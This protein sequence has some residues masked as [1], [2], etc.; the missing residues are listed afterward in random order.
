MVSREGAGLAVPQMPGG[1]Q[2]LHQGQGSERV[3]G[4]IPQSWEFGA[5]NISELV[6]EVLQPKSA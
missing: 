4:I 1:T 6:S 2:G 3:S 5:P